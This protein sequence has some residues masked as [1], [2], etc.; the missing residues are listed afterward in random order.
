MPRKAKNLCSYRGCQRK[1]WG[2]SKWC[3][4]HYA[5]HWEHREITMAEG[6]VK[7]LLGY[8]TDLVEWNEKSSDYM[9]DLALELGRYLNDVPI[10]HSNYLDSQWMLF[11][12]AQKW[13]KAL[14]SDANQR[15][16]QIQ[17]LVY[18]DG[19]GI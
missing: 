13:A 9:L 10:S 6:A 3:S 5:V 11:F 18:P 15:L 4:K 16:D 8:V 7:D 12:E 2:G 1:R 14:K 17:D 19:K